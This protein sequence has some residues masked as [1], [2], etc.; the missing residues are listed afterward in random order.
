MDACRFMIVKTSFYGLGGIGKFVFFLVRNREELGVVLQRHN[1]WYHLWRQLV[2]SL[3]LYQLLLL[4]LQAKNK[5]KITWFRENK[6]NKKQGLQQR[7]H[8]ATAQRADQI[9]E[10][11]QTTTGLRNQE[12]VAWM[13]KPSSNMINLEDS[14]LDPNKRTGAPTEEPRMQ[15]RDFCRYGKSQIN[16]P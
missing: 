6:Q 13:L 5:D 9:R 12:P 8:T 15:L 10:L 7:R 16:F 4:F 2:A 11:I 3:M 1:F 14:S